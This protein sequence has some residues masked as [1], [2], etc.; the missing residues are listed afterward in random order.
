MNILNLLLNIPPLKQI[1]DIIKNTLPEYKYQHKLYLISLVDIFFDFCVIFLIT[2]GEF[3]TLI[4]YQD[5]ITKNII[6]FLY[7]K[8]SI[9]LTLCTLFGVSKN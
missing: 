5:D 2:K 1:R 6:H 9:V 8:T 7:V 4:N 3:G